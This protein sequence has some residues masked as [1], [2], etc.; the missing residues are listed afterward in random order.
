MRSR[1]LE[2]PALIASLTLACGGPLAPS[3]PTT[4]TNARSEDPWLL[5]EPCVSP[6][7]GT[8]PALDIKVLAEGTG[9]PVTPG[10]TVR[11]HYVAS[12]PDGRVVHDVDMPSEI[13]VG[14]A[15]TICGFDRA[16]VGMRPG[17]QR[18]VTVPWHLALGDA[19]RPPEVPPRSDLVFVIDL[20]LPAS[21]MTDNGAP[22][23]NPNPTRPGGRGQH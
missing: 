2:T 10:T 22:P 19:G 15:K 7:T 23:V 1:L 11:V 6:D 9:V 3:R 16:L 12:L 17:E 14:S 21:A 20:Y 18:R 8:D 4:A 13:N 5:G